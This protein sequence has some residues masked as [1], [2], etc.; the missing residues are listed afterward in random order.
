MLS[1]RFLGFLCIASKVKKR[2]RK[3]KRNMEKRTRKAV[4]NTDNIFTESFTANHPANFVKLV[5]TRESKF[6]SDLT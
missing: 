1:F 6:S 3:R 4:Q 5:F 2:M